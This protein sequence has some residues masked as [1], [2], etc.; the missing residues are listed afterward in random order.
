MNSPEDKACDFSREVWTSVAEFYKSMIRS[1]MENH[2]NIKTSDDRIVRYAC[3]AEAAIW[4]GTGIM[5]DNSI[6]KYKFG[7]D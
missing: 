3:L 2:S 5:D 6:A 7:E 1:E 4:Q